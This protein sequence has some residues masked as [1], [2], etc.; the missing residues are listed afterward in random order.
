MAREVIGRLLAMRPD[1]YRLLAPESRHAAGPSAHIWEQLVLPVRAARLRA[2]LVYSPANIAP[3]AWP[4]SVLVIHDAAVWRSGGSY[5]RAYVAWHK[6]TERQ[7]ARRSLKV[8]S[9]SEFSK[10]ELI[11]LLGVDP[12]SI[13][14]VPNGVSDIF[15]PDADPEPPRR[16]H[17]LRRPY[18]LSVA[19]SH[20]SKNLGLLSGLAREL[21]PEGVE[22]VHVGDRRS[23]IVMGGGPAGVRSIGYIPDRDLPG[24]YCGAMVLVVPSRYEGFGMPC[25]EAMACGTPVVAANRAALP[26]TCGDAAV[27]ADPDDEASFIASVVALIDDGPHREQ[28]RAAGLARAGQFSWDHA[29][30][31]TDEILVELAG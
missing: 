29:A 3:L 31:R 4:R 14:V 17:D 21:E 11:A 27:L 18:V 23:H 7:S 20:E 24:L 6:L 12:D 15:R 19:M 1:T 13:I 2:S 25:L 10:R 9:V 5:S 30:Q 8:L 22:V 16:A 26:E 28:L